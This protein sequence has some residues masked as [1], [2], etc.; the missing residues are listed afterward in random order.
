[1]IIPQSEAHRMAELHIIGQIIGASGFPQSSLF[2]KWGIHTGALSCH[3]VTLWCILGTMRTILIFI[4]FISGGAWRLL[5]GLKEG[6]T[7]VDIP[8]IGE[9]AYWS[10]PIDLHYSTKGLQGLLT[11]WFCEI[12]WCVVSLPSDW[13][14]NFFFRLAKAACTGLAPG[15]FWQVS[16]VRL[17]LLPCALQSRTA[18][19]AVCDMEASGNLAGTAG[20]DVC[21]RRPSASLSWPHLQWSRQI[22]ASYRGYGHSR[23]GAVR[24]SAAFWALWRRELRDL[25]LWYADSNI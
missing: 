15:L 24:H 19:A 7:Q 14:Y 20:P 22:Q 12:S 25:R 3:F 11:S 1:M 16:A 4:S 23:T 8:Q 9:M 6:Q 21:W 10:H 13:V 5:S 2:C 17:R 18:P